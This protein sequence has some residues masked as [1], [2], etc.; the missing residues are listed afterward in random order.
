MT[1][2]FRFDICLLAAEHLVVH[3]ISSCD[4]RSACLSPHIRPLGGPV[5][6]M[7]TLISHFLNII[8]SAS[9][10]PPSSMLNQLGVGSAC[11]ENAHFCKCCA[12]PHPSTLNWGGQGGGDDNG[13]ARTDERFY[14]THRK[15]LFVVRHVCRIKIAHLFNNYL[16]FHSA[17]LRT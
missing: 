5:R 16:L 15:D 2:T 6:A 17:W 12:R 11:D 3:N 7:K 13:R 9:P 8:I 14:R 10:L 1:A 4:L